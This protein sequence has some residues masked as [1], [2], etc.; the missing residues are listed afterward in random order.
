M[1]ERLSETE[2][3]AKLHET[4]VYGRVHVENQLAKRT[5]KHALN[6]MLP[7]SLSVMQGILLTRLY[8]HAAG[9]MT[10]MYALAWLQEQE[11]IAV[12]N[13]LRKAQAGSC[14]SH[15]GA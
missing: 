9:E 7:Q 4:S 2:S 15:H 6:S 14:R 13:P 10:N 5:A 8:V 11:S 1:T 12:C 3:G